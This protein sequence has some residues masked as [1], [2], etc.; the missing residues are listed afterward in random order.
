MATNQGQDSWEGVDLPYVPDGDLDL[1]DDVELHTD[2]DESVDPVTHEVIRHSLWNANRENGNTIENLA[3][4]LIT[5]ATRD[6]QTAILTED[7]EFVY[8]GPYLQYFAGTIDVFVKWVMEN[9]GAEPGIGEDDMFLSNDPWVVSPHQPDVGLIAPVFHDGEIFCWVANMMHHNDVGGVDPGSFCLSAAD[10]FDDPPCLP[11]MK[12]VEGGDIR[13]E[14]EDVFKRTSRQ[15]ENVAMDLRAGIAGNNVAK[16]RINDL[17]DTYGAET[18]KGSMRKLIDDGESNF[19]EMLSRIPDGVWRERI[20]NEVATR[21]DDGV[22]PVQMNLRK[23]GE[24]LYFDNAGTGAQV[25]AINNTY[26]VWR[27]CIVSMVNLLMQPEGMGA[28]GGLLRCLEFDLEPRTMNAPEY[29]IAIDPPELGSAVSPAGSTTNELSISMANSVISK[30]LLSTDDEQLRE[31]ALGPTM[32]QWQ[33]QI[34]QGADAE[35]TPFIGPLLEGM[36]GAIGPTPSQDGDFANGLPW[37]PEGRGPN[38][39]ENE[40]RYPML[41][42]YRK[43]HADSAGAG[44]Y[45]SGNGGQVAY[46]LHKGI[47]ELSIYAA[48]GVPKTAGLFGANPG[49]RGE[50]RIVHGS[51]VNESLAASDPPTDVA[52]IDGQELL[53]EGKGG[54]VG[55]G[56]DSVVDWW[57]ATPGGY[58]DP[59]TRDPERVAEDVRTGALTEETAADRYGVVLAAD[60]SVDEAATDDRRAQ[61]REERLDAAEEVAP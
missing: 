34:I 44:K 1:P 18:V 14:R 13:E 61:L 49:N 57:W 48:D 7:G 32:G 8:F 40:R 3:V 22:Y 9:R 53:T 29:G 4:S 11:P 43:E 45:R 47:G 20:Y 51:D 6:F 35:G 60:G 42:L 25:G 23:E 28:T 33:G 46:K 38:V 31:R 26:A 55:L 56:E 54:G 30:M 39:E 59:L 21:G 16:D 17:I 37:V 12:M 52:D 2:T 5:L 27:G 41:Y 19:R 36:I 24:T 58:G 15:P 50:T 10:I